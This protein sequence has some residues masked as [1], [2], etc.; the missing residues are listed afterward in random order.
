MI[1]ILTFSCG[2]KDVIVS[3]KPLLNELQWIVR[4]FLTIEIQPNSEALNGGIISHFLYCRMLAGSIQ[5]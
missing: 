3:L 2:T 4:L 5:A 1:I